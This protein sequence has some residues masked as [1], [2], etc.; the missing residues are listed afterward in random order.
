MIITQHDSL[1]TGLQNSAVKKKT[2]KSTKSAI[3]EILMA[4]MKQFG[5]NY[6]FPSQ[7]KILEL[8]EKI[9]GIKIQRRAL[10]YALR[11]LVDEGLIKRTR[12]IAKGSGG[13][14][15]FKSTIYAFAQLGYRMLN[16]IKKLGRLVEAQLTQ[17]I[18]NR[19][20]RRHPANGPPAFAVG[21]F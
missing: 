20:R 15:I 11:D 14:L 1:C 18:D 8:L 10:N 21:G 13:L 6:C 7:A 2:R 4:L 16:Q 19:F 9:H 5:K 12:R 17:A 3:L